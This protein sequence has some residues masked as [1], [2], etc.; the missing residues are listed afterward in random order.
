[1]GGGSGNPGLPF[2]ESTTKWEEHGFNGLDDFEYK[3]LLY[4]VGQN[5]QPV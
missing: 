1:M 5:M 3:S 4:S 2:N